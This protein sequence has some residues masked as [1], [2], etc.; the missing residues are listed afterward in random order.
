MN[1]SRPYKRTDRVAHEI[2]DILGSIQTQHINL[3]HLGFVTFTS[4][5]ISPDLRSAKVFFSLVR[6]KK[7][8]HKV[9]SELNKLRKA[10]RKYLGHELAIKFTPELKFYYDDSFEYTEKLDKIFQNIDI[11]EPEI[12][13]NK[14][15]S[16]S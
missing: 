1:S 8:P 9:E 3:S 15:T 13:S 6:P 2:L 16:E 7:D 4:I 10:F 11:I 14:N 5:N 12:E